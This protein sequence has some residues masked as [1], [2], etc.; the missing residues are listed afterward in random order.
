[1][2]SSHI[3]PNHLALQMSASHQDEEILLVW[4]KNKDCAATLTSVFKHGTTLC[5]CVCV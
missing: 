1:M 2:E 3:L 5:V 4:A